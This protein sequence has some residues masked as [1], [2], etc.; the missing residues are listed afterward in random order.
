L[1]GDAGLVVA[2]VPGPSNAI[3]KLPFLLCVWDGYDLPDDFVAGDDWEAVAEQAEANCVVGMTDTTSKN[4]HQNLGWS[5]KMADRTIVPSIMHTSPEFG[6]SSFT[7]L[8]LIGSPFA[9]KTPTLYSA[10]RFGADGILDGTRK[11]IRWV[12]R[13][14]VK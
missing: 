2:A 5:V 9:S 6:N 8:N 13:S 12:S 4:L 1:T 10:G 11:V 3:S 7:C 14:F